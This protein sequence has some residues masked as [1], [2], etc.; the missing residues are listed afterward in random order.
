MGGFREISAHSGV[1]DVIDIFERQA[2]FCHKKE[3]FLCHGRRVL[4]E[5]FPKPNIY[6]DGKRSA[7]CSFFWNKTGS[8]A[9]GN[10]WEDI[11]SSPKR[12]IFP[13]AYR[14]CWQ[15]P[16]F[17]WHRRACLKHIMIWCKIYPAAV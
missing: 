9:A 2:F 14:S 11:L 15:L 10:T 8:V 16:R 13:H 17:A 12:S 5:K 6:I 3:G 7:L 1:V 4:Y